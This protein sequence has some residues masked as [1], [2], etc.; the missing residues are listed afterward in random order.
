VLT[1]YTATQDL[2]FLLNY[3]TEI[4]FYTARFWISRLE[5]NQL[6]DRY[7]LN[8]VIG[9]DEF[10]EH[11]NNNAY[12]NRLAQWNLERAYEIFHWLEKEHHQHLS[13]LQEKL[14]LSATEVVAWQD[15]ARKIY[16]PYDAKKHLIEEF[17]GYFKLQDLPITSQ[18]ENGMPQYPTGRN[19]FNC[20]DIMLIK[21]A[22]VVMLLYIL[23]AEFDD[24]TKKINY[25]FYEKRTL[26]KS[27]LSPSIYS[28]MAIE[29]NDTQKVMQYFKHAA[30]VDLVDN[31]GNAEWG[32]HIAS[33]GGIW[34]TLVFGFGGMRVKNGKLTFKPWLPQEWQQIKFKIQWQSGELV[35]TVHHSQIEFLWTHPDMINLEIEAL[36][37]L[38][39][40][41]NN[42]SKIIKK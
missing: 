11:I 9:P 30:N 29:A 41:T 1:Y 13:S 24:Q 18:D 23:P 19:H 7:E 15:F 36:S 14:K 21:Q 42:Q 16:I 5:Y 3:G 37:K 6:A 39:T 12:T 33:A 20:N 34:Q 22:D 2:E 40:L 32:I 4:L 10:H 31:Q 26:H 27:S 35:V 38:V 25:E 8:C 28:I 17:E